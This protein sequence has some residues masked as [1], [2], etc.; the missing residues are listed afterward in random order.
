MWWRRA[1]CHM[2]T[3]T[4]TNI[5]MEKKNRLAWVKTMGRGGLGGKW[6]R[7]HETDWAS[8]ACVR[9]SWFLVTVEPV[10]VWPL[11]LWRQCQGNTAD[12][13]LAGASASLW[14]TAGRPTPFVSIRRGIG[15]LEALVTVF[16]FHLD[17]PDDFFYCV[18]LIDLSLY[19]SAVR[20]VIYILIY[21]TDSQ[22]Y[23]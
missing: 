17:S 20:Q 6:E 12:G 15:A 2:L 18:H 8:S 22:Y 11:P 4:P 23:R 9:N 16:I 5:R 19:V 1:V 3:A 13:W 10:C 21:I 14:Y 7:P